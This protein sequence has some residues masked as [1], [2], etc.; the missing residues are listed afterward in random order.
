MSIIV[1][2]RVYFVGMEECAGR[3]GTHNKNKEIDN[4]YKCQ[5]VYK[6]HF[7]CACI[8]MLQ[9]VAANVS[10][11]AADLCLMAREERWI[12]I[13]IFFALAASSAACLLLNYNDLFLDYNDLLLEKQ[14]QQLARQSTLC[15]AQ[16]ISL[17]I[18]VVLNLRRFGGFVPKICKCCY[19]QMLKVSGRC[20]LPTPP[21]WVIFLLFFS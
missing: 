13:K 9:K 8:I 4:G 19:K 12:L 18:I 16:G 11:A 20:W 17:Y 6:S 14:Y 15:R 21:A 10:F 1:N 3:I 7:I 5:L 2:S